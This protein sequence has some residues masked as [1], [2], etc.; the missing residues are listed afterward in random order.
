MNQN[1][2]FEQ[3]KLFIINNGWYFSKKEIA[4]DSRLEEDLNITGDDAVEF[5][6]EF[7]KEFNVDV[8]NFKADAYFYEEGISIISN[9]LFS[10]KKKV[11]TIKDLIIAII[12]QKTC[13]V[14][15]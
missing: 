1:H 10:H 5:I 2:I 12:K 4:Q 13:L 11:L 3:I 9:F 8:S 6:I 14:C 7:G 15:V